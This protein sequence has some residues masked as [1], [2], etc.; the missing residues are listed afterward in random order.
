MRF[1]QFCARKGPVV[2]SLFPQYSGPMNIALRIFVALAAQVLVATVASADIPVDTSRA[3]DLQ[4]WKPQIAAY[5]RRHYGQSQWDLQPRCI[6][7]HYT[8][9]TG[10]PWN[11]VHSSESAGEA[12]G[13]AS[14]YV[15]D[16]RKV[17]EVLPPSVRSRGCYGLNHRAIN[18]ELVAANSADLWTR[19]RT[20]D[21]ASHLIVDLMRRYRIPAG[22]VYSHL[23]V[24]TMN[25]R[26]V[27]GV[28]DLV[29]PSPYDK[30]D[31]GA[32]N[33]HYILGQVSKLRRR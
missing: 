9:G 25:P 23:Q 24:A 26:L 33:M 12:P 20:M 19:K 7:L 4:A 2:F 21:T 1:G 28:K 30:I 5:S 13:L 22:A 17:W 15:V 11:L 27:P 10:F 29:D 14:H 31:P 6:V 32:R 8:A 3:R 16:G 18:I